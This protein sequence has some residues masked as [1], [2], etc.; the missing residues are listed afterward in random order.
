MIVASSIDAAATTAG[1]GVT[2]AVTTAGVAA[3]PI[4]GQSTTG[5][6]ASTTNILPSHCPATPQVHIG[7]YQSWSRYRTCHPVSPS[8]IPTT[9]LSHLIYSFAGIKD[10]KLDAYNGV[11][12]E[13]SA[14]AEFNSLGVQT[15]IA[16]GGWTF[17]QSLFTEVASTLESRTLFADSCVQFMM[18]HGFAGLDI[19]WEYPVTRQGSS[20][21]Y[22]NLVLLI[23]A[24][25]AAFG[26]NYLLTVAIPSNIDT[27]TQGYNLQEIQK[28]VDWFHIMSYDIHGS[29]DSIAGSNT[30]Y[31][32]ISDTVEYLMQYVPPEKLVLGLASYG[33]SVS[34]VD[35]TCT[36]AGCEINGGAITGCSGELGFLPYF[37]LKEKYIDTKNYDS[38]LF[39]DV[40]KSMEMVVNDG[41]G[42]K[43]WISLDVE[44]SWKVKVDFANEK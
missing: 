34:L 35:S 7:Y 30:D 1:A 28:E 14:Y 36:T 32:F 42:G 27:L 29:W 38:L 24:L 31:G 43:V 26:T 39:N 17:D 22:T 44:Q 21:D 2:A 4:L 18:T 9:G 25:R 37:E 23:Q 40:T 6:T 33:R 41:A 15:L 5:S 16:V 13:F 8:S 19:D 3:D 20:Q 12:E 11:V 10:G